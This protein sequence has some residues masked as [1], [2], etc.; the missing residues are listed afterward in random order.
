VRGDLQT[1]IPAAATVAPGIVLPF[2][3]LLGFRLAAVYPASLEANWL[4][5]VTDTED[6]AG[7]VRAIRSVARRAI[8]IPLVAAAAVVQAPLW[9]AG[10]TVPLALICLVIGLATAEWMFLGFGRIPFTCSYRPGKA[11]L[12]ASWPIAAGVA[13]VY[14]VA[15]PEV[16]AQ[17]IADGKAW[18]TL[19]VLLG[20]LWAC[21]FLLARRS[22][23]GAPVFDDRPPPYVTEL[24]L[25]D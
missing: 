10:V 22:G 3:G 12:R 4:F 18:R 25:D 19:L 17:A 7:G 21:F 8:V 1:A 14:C 20:L 16:V 2:F 13:F 24:R 15:L 9:G 6:A 23:R 5:R 11:N